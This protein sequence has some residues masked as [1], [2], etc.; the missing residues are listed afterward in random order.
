MSLVACHP[1]KK[2]P[3]GLKFRWKTEGQIPGAEGS[4]GLAGPVAGL[5]NGVLL[6]GAGSNFPEGS[7]WDGG[8]KKY[9]NELYVFHKEG[10]TLLPVTGRFFLPYKVAY[11]ANCTTEEGIV[12]A[13]GENENGAL[14]RVLSLKWDISRQ[15]V[16]IER[17]PDLPRPLSSGA[18]AAIGKDIYFAGGQDSEMV[19]GI[20]YHL[21]LAHPEKGWDTASMLP[22][23]VTHTVLYARP[24]EAARLFLAGGRKGNKDSI[25]TLYDE[26]YEFNPVDGKWTEKASLPYALSAQ[27]G[28]TWDDSILL[29]FSGDKGETFHETEKLILKIA[30]ET[31]PAERRRL[32]EEKNELQKS[33]PGFE[34][35]TL[36]Y[37]IRKDKWTRT[38]SIPFPGQV[39]TTAVKWNDEVI[40]PCGEIRA[41]VRTPEII[42]GKAILE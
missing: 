26:V 5:S 21:D 17:L 28:I 42:V 18:V 41:G 1:V 19:S 22:E 9:Y 40:I 35:V 33:H 7:P 34:G 11:S 38:D 20:L 8:T 16:V 37:D 3:Q 23:K 13:G 24:G 27:T 14:D 2:E 30:H 32:V 15:D 36:A 4:L 39:T 6:V 25:S 29:M 31:D 12:V 10:D